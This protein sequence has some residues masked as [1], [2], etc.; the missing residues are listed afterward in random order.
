MP[1]RG[2]TGPAAPYRHGVDA[3][4]PGPLIVWFDDDC[5]VCSASVRF[6]DR[7]ADDT[8]RFRPSRG[9]TDPAL[10]A[11]SQSALLV[12]GPDGIDEGRAAVA[13]VLG[14][15]GRLGRGASRVLGLPGV[16]RVGDLVYRWVAANRSRIS[17]WLHLPATCDLPPNR[18]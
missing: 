18:S 15:C 16:D 4:A 11:R 10:I 14:R 3:S 17:R 1:R 12:V 7:H 6:L 9:L 5:G 2:G 13:R 8:V